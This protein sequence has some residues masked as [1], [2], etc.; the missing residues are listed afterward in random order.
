MNLLRFEGLSYKEIADVMGLGLQAT[1]SLLNRAKE[2]LRA[3]LGTELG[4]EPDA[5]S[6]VGGDGLRRER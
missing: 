2:N 3:A 6:P 1:K 5:R 4:R